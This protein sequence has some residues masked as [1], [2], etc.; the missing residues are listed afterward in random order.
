M[1]N[2]S[3]FRYVQDLYLVRKAAG[4]KLFYVERSYTVEFLLDGIPRQY[5]V[6]VGTWTDFA[7]VPAVVPRWIVEKI[8]SHLEASVVHDHMCRMR[9]WTSD[10]VHDIFLAAM[11]A[12]G[13][14]W[15][16]RHLMYRAVKTFG[17]V[18]AADRG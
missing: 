11:E 1:A 4:G 16:T 10:I 17:S 15:T 9:V 12:A 6:P 13:V 18:W 7:S 14:P 5:T 8:D 2:V 3:D